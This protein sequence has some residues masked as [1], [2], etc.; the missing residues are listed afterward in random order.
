MKADLPSLAQKFDQQLMSLAVVRQN[1]TSCP[2]DLTLSFLPSHLK[3]S[4]RERI[5]VPDVIDVVMLQTNDGKYVACFC[6]NGRM[7]TYEIGDENKVYSRVIE[8]LQ[9]NIDAH[10]AKK[11]AEKDLY[12]FIDLNN[13][14]KSVVSEFPED[15]S[16]KDNGSRFV[17]S[18]YFRESGSTALR[19]DFPNNLTFLIALPI[20][21]PSYVVCIYINGNYY[22]GNNDFTLSEL[23]ST[24]KRVWSV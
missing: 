3:F 16:H 12:S 15:L 7:S 13:G 19:V 21:R 6:F 18:N 24:L 14:I 20:S 10:E 8:V 2:D 22:S 9:L 5:S 23:T 11:R 4:F 17:K 1:I